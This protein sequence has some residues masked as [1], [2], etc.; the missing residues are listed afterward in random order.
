MI[1]MK[2]DLDTGWSLAVEHRN[3]EDP[4][5]HVAIRGIRND[6]LPPE[7]PRDYMRAGIRA[8]TEDLCTRR[9]AVA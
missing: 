3:K 9:P 5:I 1:R 8:I 4:H 6:G 7:L 2:K